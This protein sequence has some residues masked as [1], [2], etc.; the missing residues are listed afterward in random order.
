MKNHNSGK[1]LSISGASIANGTQPAQRN[2]GDSQ[3]QL[4]R[5]IDR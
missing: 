2:Y 3:D 1:C 4:W 5:I